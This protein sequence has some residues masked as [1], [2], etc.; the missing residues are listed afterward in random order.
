MEPF[1]KFFGNLNLYSFA[2]GHIPQNTRLD[3]IS[4]AVEVSLCLAILIFCVN[5]VSFTN[6]ADLEVN[7][8]VVLLQTSWRNCTFYISFCFS[9]LVSTCAPFYKL[10]SQRTDVFELSLGRLS[11]LV[12]LGPF[13]GVV[14]PLRLLLT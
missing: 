10:S 6:F 4:Q 8:L 3:Q 1:Q 9:P 11:G 5:D 7:L 12:I 2:G 14:A 13:Y